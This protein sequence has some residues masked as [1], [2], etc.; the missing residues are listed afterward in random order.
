M[1]NAAHIFR[2][3][4]IALCWSGISFLQ[5]VDSFSAIPANA[6]FSPS[7][8]EQQQKQVSAVKD[9]A[10]RIRSTKESDIHQ[11][12]SDIW[13]NTI[14]EGLP[15]RGLPQR[16]LGD[17]FTYFRRRIFF[18]KSKE[19]VEQLLQTRLKA[20]RVGTKTIEECALYYDEDDL[21]ES[22]KLRYLWSNDRFRN[23]FEKAAR[24][25]KEPHQW[26]SYNFACAPERSDC[27]QHKMLTAEDRYT[28]ELLGFCEIAMLVDP[29]EQHDETVHVRPSIVNLIV[30][31]KHRR[32]GVATRILRS[33]ENYVSREWD[34]DELNLFVDQDNDAAVSL[35]QG[36]G[37]QKTATSTQ[38][39]RKVTQLYMT[40]P[41]R[42][43]VSHNK[44]SWLQPSFNY[45]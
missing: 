27:L 4:L 43:R 29:T 38:T 1:A 10:F 3:V 32:R 5:V 22:E 8:I 13:A 40:L 39:D 34:A 24:I 19:C 6:N 17:S 45:C 35:Y 11:G 7:P 31:P 20:I 44:R 2:I 12:V 26:K 18:L 33:A 36:L 37:F 23:C 30:S 15:Q 42:S 9:I 14:V 28:G 16:G 25:S 21:S 41:F